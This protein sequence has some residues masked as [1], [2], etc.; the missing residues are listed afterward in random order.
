ME[1]NPIVNIVL[2][3]SLAIIMF[4]MGTTLEKKDFNPLLRAPR[5]AFIGVLG[6]M[7]LL[8]LLGLSTIYLFE[9]DASNAVGLLILTACAGGPV[10][11]LI[12]YLLKA[13]VALSISLTAASCLLT[14]FTIPLWVNYG[15][16]T[17]LKQEHPASLP[18]A[19][20]NLILFAVTVFPVI[21]GMWL[22]QFARTLALRLEKPL[23][24]IAL[25]FFLLIVVGIIVKEKARL[26]EV[27]PSLG[28][29]AWTL[30]IVSMLLAYG[31]AR[32]FTLN[33]AQTTTISIEVGLQN[34]ATGIFVAA[35][36]LS[37]PA[38]AVF[39]AVYAV[40]MMV[41]VAVLTIALKVRAIRQQ[42]A[43]TLEALTPD[44][45]KEA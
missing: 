1:A 13:D 31:L 34:S 15:L 17:F 22:R 30:N 24:V 4:G 28:P 12:C 35:G 20:T 19:Q 18:V 39:P 45:R 44:P 40:C 42:R 41:N 2:P 21:L 6:Q 5:A 26:A 11:N 38:L 3:L 36:L 7:L 9:L 16:D 33:Q 29:A 10:S 37:Q 25:L 14:I 23:N 8:P 32:F 43:L 27:L